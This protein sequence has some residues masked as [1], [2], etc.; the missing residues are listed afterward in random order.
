V[1][2]LVSSALAHL[3]PRRYVYLV[4]GGKLD[5]SVSPGI[6]GILKEKLEKWL[7]Y[8]AFKIS[9]EDYLRHKNRAYFEPLVAGVE[10]DFL[11]ENRYFSNDE[12]PMSKLYLKIDENVTYKRIV[13]H[14]VVKSGV[15]TYQNPFDILIEPRRHVVVYHLP[16]IPL[17]DISIRDG[18]IY[19]TIDE[20]EI[21]GAAIDGSDNKITFTSN[22]GLPLYDEFLNDDWVRK[23]DTV[24]NLSYLNNHF[25][26]F[27]FGFI[28]KL[29]GPL[30]LTYSRKR[31]KESIHQ[32]IR[33][34][35]CRISIDIIANEKLCKIIWWLTMRSRISYLEK[36][37]TKTSR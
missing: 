4:R 26:N 19:T 25:V 28:N 3:M 11:L 14:V 31:A 23:W 30:A 5:I 13:G 35:W 32:K 2:G 22:S 20:I 37:I 27:R 18:K 9:H 36:H 29:A 21:T 34:Y 24:W 33:R 17:K 6:L 1:F 15:L 12:S 10:Y 7:C 16:N 8:K